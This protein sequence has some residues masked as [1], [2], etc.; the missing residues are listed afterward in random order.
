MAK[1]RRSML[2][3]GIKPLEVPPDAGVS[4]STPISLSSWGFV[5]ARTQKDNLHVYKLF[6]GK[7]NLVF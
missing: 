2:D 1:H 6:L 5:L 7:G 4:K 3:V